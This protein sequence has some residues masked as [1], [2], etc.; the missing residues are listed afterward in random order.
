MAKLSDRQKS[1]CDEYLID[2]NA[3]QAAIRAGYSTTYATDHAY[4]LL[5]RPQIKEYVARAMAERSK[6]TGI[7]QD[8]VIQELAK[9][10]LIKASDV[11]NINT[12]K[13]KAKAKDEDL[14]VIQS[15]KIK[16]VPTKFGNGVER[17]IKL[18]DKTKALELLGKHLGMFKEK[19][20]IKADVN[21]TKKL[22]SILEQLT[23]DED[24]E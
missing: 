19:I 22:D 13:V 17:E 12:A 6:R 24:N 18:A 10:A 11:M 8:R 23:G 2:L 9:I 3:H 16:T 1:F 14:A 21:S 20:D 15:V 4:E 5:Q 7:N